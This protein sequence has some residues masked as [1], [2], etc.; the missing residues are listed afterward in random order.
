MKY[1]IQIKKEDFDG[2]GGMNTDTGI[3]YDPVGRRAYVHTSERRTA[4][5]IGEWIVKR[6]DGSIGVYS[7]L[8]YKMLYGKEQKDGTD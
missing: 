8:V 6:A 5:D 7:D 3:I 2:P 4:V 1:A